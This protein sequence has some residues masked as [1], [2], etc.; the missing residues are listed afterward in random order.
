MK[1]I[2]LLIGS[3][4]KYAY[5]WQPF[6]YFFNK[7]ILIDI[8]KYLIS[9]TITYENPEYNTILC[10]KIPYSECLRKALNH[11]NSKYILWVQDD[12]FFFN[13]ISEETI[14]NYIKLMNN[15]NI[16]RLGIYHNLPFYSFD[17]NDKIESLIRLKQNSQY[18]ISMQVSI[19]NREFFISCLSDSP[20]N[21]WQFEING[22]NRLNK[23]THKTYIDITDRWY[24][25]VM[26]K[27]KPTINYN[28]MIKTIKE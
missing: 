3:C 15:N 8:D 1:D 17:Y 13:N 25:D 20:E 24:F 28:N 14:K 12:Y 21:P 27:G 19:W 16:D 2:S 23:R 7:H 5:L 4:D 18:T 22:S 9:E 26:N 11:I 10:G 6:N